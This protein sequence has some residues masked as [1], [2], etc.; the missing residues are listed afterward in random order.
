[1]AISPEEIGRRDPISTLRDHARR[2]I[3]GALRVIKDDYG[4]DVHMGAELYAFPQDENGNPVILHDNNIARLA[5]LQERAPL[6]KRVS[7]SP[8]DPLKPCPVEFASQARQTASDA[9]KWNPLYVADQLDDLKANMPAIARSLGVA[10]MNMNAKPYADLP[11]TCGMHL[12]ISLWKNGENMFKTPDPG[13]PKSHVSESHPDIEQ[14]VTHG[15]LQIQHEALLSF[16]PSKSSYDRFQN[17]KDFE[18]K[19]QSDQVEI[20]RVSSPNTITVDNDRQRIMKTRLS[21]MEKDGKTLAR[22]GRTLNYIPT[23]ASLNVHTI[24]IH[25]SEV[26]RWAGKVPVKPNE[27]HI[28]SRLSGSDADPYVT[29]ALALAGVLLGL[30]AGKSLSKGED[31]STHDLTQETHE[32]A[33]KRF[34]DS[35]IIDQVLPPA[36]KEAI[37]SAYG[38]GQSLPQPERV[39]GRG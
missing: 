12:N 8:D 7:V 19:S 10:S 21:L 11:D 36:F 38:L 27:C 35:K 9:L 5:T 28:E 15:L 16:A 30:K 33:L 22:D 25:S 34:K 14:R 32:T 17:F 29:T 3:R 24:G 26:R 18:D 2:Y 1:M 39:T 31:Y 13:N 6:F 20:L 37:L 23:S 4:Y